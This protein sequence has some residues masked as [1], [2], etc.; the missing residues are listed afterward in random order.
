MPRHSASST[1][2]IRQRTETILNA[3]LA[4]LAV[5]GFRA[6]S[7]ESVA[8]KAGVN[9]TTVYRRWPTK[10]LLVRAA[11][12]SKM[13]VVLGPPHTGTLRGDLI[14]V[15]RAF[16]QQ[17]SSVEGQGLLRVVALEQAEP[18]VAEARAF[19]K[20]QHDAMIAGL[21]D[22]AVRRGELTHAIDS[23]VLSLALVGPLHLRVFVDDERADEVF[24]ARLV[25]LLLF[26]LVPRP[27]GK[28]KV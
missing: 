2:R 14:A 22:E 20:Q 26:G 28:S 15:A 4:D 16:V 10:A 11:I 5:V 9:K 18:V 17:A 24:L 7:V 8:T 12:E 19:I 1:P 13:A 27:R 3:V 25:D 21:V 23:N 6:L